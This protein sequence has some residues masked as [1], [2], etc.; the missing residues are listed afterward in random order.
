MSKFN[1]QGP[2][3]WT[4]ARVEQLLLLV[5]RTP[6]TEP[7]PPPARGAAC[8]FVAACATLLLA[9]PLSV[10]MGGHTPEHS[11][12]QAVN[13]SDSED[14]VVAEANSSDDDIAREIEDGPAASEDPADTEHP[15]ETH[16]AAS[17]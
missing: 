15:E 4:E 13:H 3:R 9:L 1:S 14:L 12:P 8:W 11:V 5:F 17:T 6:A 10:W 7:S 2:E 16:E